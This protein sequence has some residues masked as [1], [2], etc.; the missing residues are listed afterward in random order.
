MVDAHCVGDEGGFHPTYIV[1]WLRFIGSTVKR[2]Y[3]LFETMVADAMQGETL[4]FSSRT[5][6][7]STIVPE[8]VVSS[9][10]GYLDNYSRKWLV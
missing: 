10:R 9:A 7:A 1:L 3:R 4:P 2:A 5:Q 6:C 8:K